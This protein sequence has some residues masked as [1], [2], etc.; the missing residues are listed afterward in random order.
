[1]KI[2]LV[3]CSL[4]M[5]GVDENYKLIEENIK[6]AC[7]DKPDVVVLP[8]LWDTSFFPENVREIADKEGQRA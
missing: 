2:S 3:Q 4:I 6:K 1:M 7:D 8:E 5:G